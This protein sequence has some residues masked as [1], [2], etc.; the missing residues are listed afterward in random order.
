MEITCKGVVTERNIYKNLNF[1]PFRYCKKDELFAILWPNLLTSSKGGTENEKCLS[2]KKNVHTKWNHKTDI[3]RP[4][5]YLIY[6]HQT[7]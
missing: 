1:L 6:S 3:N 7:L 5:A 4:M 2:R